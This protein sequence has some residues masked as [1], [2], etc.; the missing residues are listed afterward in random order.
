MLKIDKKAPLDINVLNEKGEKTSLQQMLGK[1]IV[2]YFYPRD[3]TPG[4]TTE[5]CSF[6]D[7]NTQLQELGVQVIGV[8]KDSIASHDKFTQKH[9]LNFPLWSDPD[10]A[11]LEAF[12][13]WK[14]KKNFGKIYMGIVRSTFIIDPQGKI[15]K[16]WEKV[17]TKTHTDEVLEFLEEYLSKNK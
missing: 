8:S 3:N 2:L 15:I 1:Y 17:K 7:A 11:L 4:C 16:T 10:H 5:A 13:A 12:G 6:R 9:S 14:E